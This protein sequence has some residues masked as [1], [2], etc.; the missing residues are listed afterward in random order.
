[1]QNSRTRR[2]REATAVKRI[3]ERRSEVRRD[4]RNFEPDNAEMTDTFAVPPQTLLVLATL[5]VPRGSHA[6]IR[7][8]AVP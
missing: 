1:M 7:K 4:N 3:S 5:S 2:V 6:S 8:T